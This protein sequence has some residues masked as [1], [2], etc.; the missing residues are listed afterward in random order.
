MLI[1]DFSVKVTSLNGYDALKMTW[2]RQ[3]AA[4]DIAAAFG[5]VT[6]RLNSSNK[7]LYVV[8]DLQEE[9]EL[10]LKETILGALSGTYRHPR[11]AEWL[12]VGANNPAEVV[13]RALATMT[14]RD[15][16]IWFDTEEQAI[17]Y[18]KHS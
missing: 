8:L 17:H 3:V 1:Q 10:P 4:E 6:D 16:V 11:L 13:G 15:N 14:N 9:P 5:E 7:P 2:Q 12:V 18:L